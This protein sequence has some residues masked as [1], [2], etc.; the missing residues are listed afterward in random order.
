MKSVLASID[1]RGD[2]KIPHSRMTKTCLET[3]VMC[4]INPFVPSVGVSAY[5]VIWGGPS[6]FCEMCAKVRKWG[7]DPLRWFIES[8]G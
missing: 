2:I 7:T 1:F 6:Q 8:C 5:Y 4:Y 3:L